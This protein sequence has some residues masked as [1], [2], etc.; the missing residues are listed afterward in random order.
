M[1]VTHV[2][3]GQTVEVDAEFFDENENPFV[4]T[5]PA[6]YSVFDYNNNLIATSTGVQDVDNPERWTGSFTIPADAP[7]SDVGQ[8]YRITWI[9][10]NALT[11]TT[12]SATD[13]F[14]VKTENDTL[15]YESGR[16]VLSGGKLNDTLISEDQIIG[17]ISYRVVDEQS[18]VLLTEIL[19]AAD[20][21]RTVN[22]FY[23]YDYES[24][25]DQDWLTPHSSVTPYFAEW[26]Y[27]TSEGA[28]VE[29]HPIYVLTPRMYMFVDGIKRIV[30]KVR[31]KD[32]NPNLQYSDIDLVHY[33]YDGIMRLNRNRPTFTNWTPENVPPV[34][35]EL[36]KKSGAIEALRAQLLAEGM[37]AFDFQG[38]SIQLNVDRTQHISNVIE[39]LERTF[40]EDVF[41]AKKIYINRSSPGVLGMTISPISNYMNMNH[42]RDRLALFRKIHF[43]S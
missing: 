3:R 27:T 23:Y 10:K 15:S 31:N 4:G 8:K 38:Q 40:E 29:I 11:N 26:R 1:K 22:G 21:D 16:L 7:V 20:I 43:F 13:Y 18:T 19:T 33:A 2:Y 5:G 30:D 35:F 14:T 28:Q 42:P 41:R 32:I 9:I 6:T 34:F 12:L 36:A 39:L 25:D 24:A 37:V 17:D